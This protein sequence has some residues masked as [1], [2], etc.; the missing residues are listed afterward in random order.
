MIFRSGIENSPSQIHLH[1]PHLRLAAPGFDVATKQFPIGILC[2]CGSLIAMRIGRKQAWRER[3]RES[4][5][6][7][8]KVT[9]VFA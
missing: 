1:V 2:A 6:E 8:L 4:E 7:N 5:G 3:G 9:D